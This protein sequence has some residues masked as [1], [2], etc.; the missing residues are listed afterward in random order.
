MMKHKNDPDGRAEDIHG[1]ADICN[2]SRNI[3]I[4]PHNGLHTS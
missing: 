4:F 2:L 3:S 1:I